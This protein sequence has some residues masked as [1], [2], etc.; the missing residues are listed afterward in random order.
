[1][2]TKMAHE[3]KNAQ[4]LKSQLYCMCVKNVGSMK[5]HVYVLHVNHVIIHIWCSF[6]F[7]VRVIQNVRQINERKATTCTQYGKKTV[8]FLLHLSATPEWATCSALRGVVVYSSKTES[9]F[10]Y[11]CW[12]S[13]LSKHLY[14]FCLF[15]LKV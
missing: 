4:H 5:L 14:T 2:E 15:V 9:E 12:A 1:M 3:N 7:S 11:S 8:F 10:A 6:D 13:Y